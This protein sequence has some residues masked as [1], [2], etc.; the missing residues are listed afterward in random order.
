[1]NRVPGVFWAALSALFFSAGTLLIKAMGPG[2][3]YYWVAFMRNLAPLPLLLLLMRGRG[4]A[5]RSPGWRSL[6]ARGALGAAAIACLAW[7]LPRMP[8]ADAVLLGHASPLY[9][10][11]FGVLLFAESLDRRALACLALAFAGVAV[12]LRPTLHF[13]SV[14]YFVA[15]AAGLLSSLAHVAVKSLSKSEPSTRIVLYAAAAGAGLF[16]PPVLTSAFSPTPLQW[17]LMLL[18][19][20][21]ITAGQLLLTGGIARAPVSTATAGL[22]MTIVMNIAGGRLFFGETPDAWSWLGCL[23]ILGGI[24]GLGLS[25]RAAPAA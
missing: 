1:V 3:P 11:V 23:L 21:T 5:V 10:A 2:V 25:R 16:L 17:G 8:L 18:V 13:D 12:T 24:G 22:F 6:L 15:L 9:S 7:A 19:G 4:Q 20:L 14:P